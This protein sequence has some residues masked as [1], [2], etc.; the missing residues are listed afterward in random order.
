M[1]DTQE[2]SPRSDRTDDVSED[3]GTSSTSSDRTNDFSED[4]GRL[5]EDFFSDDECS[6]DPAF[7][8][9]PSV[10]PALLHLLPKCG[11][12]VEK[13]VSFLDK[14]EAAHGMEFDEHGVAVLPKV[15]GSRDR[16]TVTIKL[17][18]TCPKVTDFSFSKAAC[19][20]L[21]V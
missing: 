15:A 19:Q 14:L 12:C 11:K 13:L 10:E 2:L 7:A 4:D 6:A 1:G 20:S 3:D 8:R 5:S 21:F 9:P 17:N 16:G 18:C